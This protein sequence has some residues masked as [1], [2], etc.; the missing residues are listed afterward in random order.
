M[1]PLRQI[2]LAGE[3]C[4]VKEAAAKK[5]LSKDELKQLAKNVGAFGVGAGLGGGAGYLVRQKLLPKILPELTP[6][7]RTAIG[8]GGGV[9]TGLLSA[10]ALKHHMRLLDESGK[11]NN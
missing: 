9:L 6:K 2:V 7:A 8:V 4:R 3:L 11:R 5:R 1:T 10:G